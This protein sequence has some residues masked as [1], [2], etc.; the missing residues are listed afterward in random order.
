MT[1]HFYIGF[2]GWLL[3][4]AWEVRRNYRIIEVHKERPDYLNSFFV[5]VFFGFLSTALMCQTWDPGYWSTWIQAVPAIVYE[6]SSFYLVFD[7]WLNIRRGK[8]WDYQGDNSGIFFDH[9]PKWLYYSLKVLCVIA[10][11]VSIVVLWK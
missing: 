11:V 8:P 3:F 1:H 4:I 9:L 2:F 10:L 7:V 5:R 6:L